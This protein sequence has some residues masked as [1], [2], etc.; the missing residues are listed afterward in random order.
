[1]PPTSA[2][3][4]SSGSGIPSSL[5]RRWKSYLNSRRLTLETHLRSPPSISGTA[6]MASVWSLAVWW[7]EKGLSSEEDAR[8]KVRRSWSGLW[9]SEARWLKR[10]SGASMLSWRTRPSFIYN[11]DNR[12]KV[13]FSQAILLSYHPSDHG[14]VFG[15]RWLDLCQC[16]NHGTVPLLFNIL[17]FFLIL[18]LRDLGILSS[19]RFPLAL[20]RFQVH[21]HPIWLGLDI[22]S[23]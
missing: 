17:L 12:W 7:A 11:Y 15:H 21:A 22:W 9:T 10:Q 3:A 23:F 16:R 8:Q 19:C 5:N 20:P 2:L 18:G 4:W 14:P 13:C 1:M 6:V